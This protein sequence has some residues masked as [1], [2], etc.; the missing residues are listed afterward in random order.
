MADD[1][2]DKFVYGPGDL[3]VSQCFFCRHLSDRTPRAC[4][5]FPHEI[6]AEILSNQYDHRKPWIDPE[7]GEPGDLGMVGTE[8][9]LFSPRDDAHPEALKALY[10]HLDAEAD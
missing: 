10:R 2:A 4:R 5:A 6:P 7:T 1:R 8:S 3:V 9:V